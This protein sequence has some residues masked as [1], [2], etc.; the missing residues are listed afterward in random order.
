MEIILLNL[1][2]I[3]LV[4]IILCVIALF[5]LKVEWNK[6]S[7]EIHKSDER[8][9]KHKFISSKIE[10]N[11]ELIATYEQ[12]RDPLLLKLIRN[13]SKEID[14]IVKSSSC[15]VIFMNTLFFEQYKDFQ[16]HVIDSLYYNH[17]VHNG[18]VYIQTHS[19]F[20]DFNK[21]VHS[22]FENLYI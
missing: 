4:I 19:Q 3:D 15:D 1:I 13:I 7:I 22:R 8:I 20:I 2:V 10:R 18:S 21:Q 5:K 14:N 12:T 9:K 16:F 17:C 6:N 11:R